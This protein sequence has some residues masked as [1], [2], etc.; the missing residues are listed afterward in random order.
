MEIKRM[1]DKKRVGK[2]EY[3]Y[4]GEEIKPNVFMRKCFLLPLYGPVNSSFCI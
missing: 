3:F 1:W 2:S 4:S